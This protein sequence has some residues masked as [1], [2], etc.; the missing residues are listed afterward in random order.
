MRYAIDCGAQLL[1]ILNEIS[2]AGRM[3][4]RL[5]RTYPIVPGVMRLRDASRISVESR[6]QV[7]F[8]L[9]RTK[10]AANTVGSFAKRG[11]T[12]VL[13]SICDITAQACARVRRSVARTAGEWQACEGFANEWSRARGILSCTIVC[14]PTLGYQEKRAT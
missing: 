6:K 9:A 11:N 4:A 10:N 2:V 7:N 12:A 8:R 1:L 3:A 13:S 5:M 14:M